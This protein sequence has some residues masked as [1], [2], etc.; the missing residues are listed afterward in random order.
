MLT[1]LGRFL[2]LFEQIGDYPRLGQYVLTTR[3]T[4]TGRW[5][6]AYQFVSGGISGALEM[7]VLS[8]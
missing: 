7:S 3:H 1:I 6:S 2:I 5:T 8:S 4:E